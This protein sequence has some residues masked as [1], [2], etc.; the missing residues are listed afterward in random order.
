MRYLVRMLVDAGCE[1]M[2]VRDRH[3]VDDNRFYDCSVPE[4]EFILRDAPGQ[5]DPSD[6]IVLPEHQLDRYLTALEAHHARFALNNQNGYL[7]MTSRPAGRASDHQIEFAIAN[8]EAVAQL[9]RT[10]LGLD[11]SRI[12]HVPHLVKTGAFDLPHVP[13]AQK[14]LAVAYMPRKLATLS[15]SIR[16]RV[17]ER[18]PDVAWVPIDG[19]PASD[20]ARLMSSCAIFMSTAHL[21]GCPLPPLEAMACGCIVAGF[22]GTPGLAHPYATSDNGLW[23]KDENETDAIEKVLQAIDLVEHQQARAERIRVCGYD[24]VERFS[25]GAVRRALEPL[26]AYL[27]AAPS[28]R[29]R[30]DR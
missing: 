3:D 19:V 8:S 21:E 4:A 15:E 25:V 24:T 12:F 14:P 17:S 23:A 11:A 16:M 1:A 18:R 9:T 22:G 28:R 10:L 13:T 2:I 27:G 29:I 26:I 20:V 5:V 6:V 7:F 30:S